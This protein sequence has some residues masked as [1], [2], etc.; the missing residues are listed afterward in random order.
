MIDVFISAIVFAITF[1]GHVVLYR[2]LQK[3]GIKSFYTVFVF[4][5][6]L[7]VLLI[8]EW[9]VTAQTPI[10]TPER[11]IVLIR[12]PLT[13]LALYLLTSGLLILFFTAPYTDE[14]SPSQKITAILKHHNG[15]TA[16]RIFHYFSEYELFGKRLQ[17]LIQ[18]GYMTG[19][20]N[21]FYIYPKGQRLV[22]LINLYQNWF[23]WK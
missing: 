6:G 19:R 15:I 9:P 3:K 16:Q 2:L 17:T 20:N 21:T 8:I 23:K 22:H 1:G 18:T 10:I 14:I 7:L 12:L 4:G 5:L 13:S 11:S